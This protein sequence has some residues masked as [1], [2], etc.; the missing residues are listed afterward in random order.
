MNDQYIDLYSRNGFAG[1]A[2]TLVRRQYAPDYNR[3]QGEYVPR[4]L[5]TGQIAPGLFADPRALPVT[6][7]E[8]SDVRLATWWRQDPTPFCIRN[9][10]ED[11][12]HFV[13][14]GTARL[15]TDFGVLDL[16]PGDFVL[17]PRSVTYRLSRVDSLRALVVGTESRLQ[18]DPD[19]APVVLDVSCTSTRPPRSR[20]PSPGTG[21]TSW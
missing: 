4:R 7:L 14:S 3:V 1:P 15:E 12:L 5:E 16:R 18:V 9:V 10:D 13:L 6:L 8:G 21:S 17:I 11:E 20:T 2:T 19:S